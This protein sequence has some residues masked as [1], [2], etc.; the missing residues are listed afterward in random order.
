MTG[1]AKLQS[2]RQCSNLIE[3]VGT[4]EIDLCNSPSWEL[5][6]AAAAA[7]RYHFASVIVAAFVAVA[8]SAVVW[9]ARVALDPFAHFLLSCKEKTTRY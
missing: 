9:P 3:C 2:G 4:C 7:R 8:A 1:L 5:R 6:T